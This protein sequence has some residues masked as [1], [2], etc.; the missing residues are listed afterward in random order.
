MSKEINTNGAPAN[1]NGCQMRSI[2]VRVSVP[3][4]IQDQADALKKATRAARQLAA[5][6]VRIKSEEL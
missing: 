5:K 2:E 1:G 3:Q 6:M 4:D